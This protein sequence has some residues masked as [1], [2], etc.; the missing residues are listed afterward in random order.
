M[1]L[2][3]I[4]ALSLVVL[5]AVLAVF[6]NGLPA[7]PSVVTDT[8]NFMIGYIRQGASIFYTYCYPEVVR[9]LVT[10]TLA[11]VA[12]YEGYKLVMWVAKKVP[13]FGVSD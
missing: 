6:G 12:I 13:M 5:T 1:I 7:F 9:P 8:Y 10:L 4:L 11:A 3:A 2:V